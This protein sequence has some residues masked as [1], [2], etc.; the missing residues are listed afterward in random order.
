MTSSFYPP[1]KTAPPSGLP[2]FSAAPAQAAAATQQRSAPRRDT[3]TPTRPKHKS[4]SVWCPSL[5]RGALAVQE[6]LL[7]AGGCESGV[8]AA[9]LLAAGGCGRCPH[10]L[11]REPQLSLCGRGLRY[12][13][14]V[15]ALCALAWGSG[16]GEGSDASVGLPQLQGPG[17]QACVQDTR[18][19]PWAV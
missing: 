14:G 18:P 5:S 1:V 3:R 7:N 6:L 4:V 8:P 12:E 19:T 16:L 15:S 11:W 9:I 2:R 17:H 13:R 10:Y